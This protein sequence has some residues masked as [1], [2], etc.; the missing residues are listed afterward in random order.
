[1]VHGDDGL[2]PYVELQTL[3]AE[4]YHE[5]LRGNI[6]DLQIEEPRKSYSFK[7][8]V[9]GVKALKDLIVLLKPE[10]G[11]ESLSINMDESGF[12]ISINMSNRA[13]AD[14]SLKQIFNKVGPQAK[15]AGYK[16]S[17]LRST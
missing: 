2:Q 5:R 15:E 3:S 7:I 14:V 6:N 13:S 10:N 8:Y 4:K 9:D 1:M 12:H 11:L 17:T 16:F